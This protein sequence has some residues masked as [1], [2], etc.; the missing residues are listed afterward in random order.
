MSKAEWAKLG[1]RPSHKTGQWDAGAKEPWKQ[2]TIY[3][4]A[5]HEA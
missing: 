1:I 3:R 5:P 2:E 4:Y